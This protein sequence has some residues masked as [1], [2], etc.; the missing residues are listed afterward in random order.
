ML[1]FSKKNLGTDPTYPRA[2]QVVGVDFYYTGN[3][4]MIIYIQDYLV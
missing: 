1:Y 3:N 2:V 4:T